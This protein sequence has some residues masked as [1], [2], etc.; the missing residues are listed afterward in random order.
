M[1][2]KLFKIQNIF[3]KYILT[4][5]NA[6]NVEVNRMK[7]VGTFLVV[8]WLKYHSSTAGGTG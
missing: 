4:V 8:L 2:T 1:K 7:D 6:S 5:T 3:K